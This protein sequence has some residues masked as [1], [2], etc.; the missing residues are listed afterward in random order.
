MSLNHHGYYK[1]PLWNITY[2][3]LSQIILMTLAIKHLSL[4][5]TFYNLLSET[6][7]PEQ[8]LSAPWK[9]PHGFSVKHIW[10]SPFRGAEATLG[11]IAFGQP[12]LEQNRTG[13]ESRIWVHWLSE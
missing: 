6:Y 5:Y 2:R 12:F 9:V 13:P 1:I 11:A 3:S 8:Q 10:T 7:R 4:Y